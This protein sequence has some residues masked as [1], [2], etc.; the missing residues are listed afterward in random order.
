VHDPFGGL[1]TGLDAVL[2]MRWKIHGYFYSDI[3]PVARAETHFRCRS[4]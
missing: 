4:F 3:D 2:R 1:C